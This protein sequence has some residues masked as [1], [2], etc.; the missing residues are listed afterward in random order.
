MDSNELLRKVRKIEIR[1][2]A[3]S[4]QIFAGEYHSAFKGRGMAFSEVREY[5]YGDDVRSM[6]WNVTAR[7]RAPYVK[8]YEEEREL[9]VMLLVD[10]SGSRL[11]GTQART[12]RELMAEIAAVLS[13]SAS[14][15]NDKVGALFFSSKVEK[16]IPPKKG[17]SHLL[18]IIR[19][20]LEFEPQEQG[21]DIGEALRFLTN[22]LKRRCTAFLLSDLMDVDAGGNPRY[23]EALKIAAGRHDLS[24][25]SVYDPRERKLPDVGLVHLRDAE[26][27][28]QLWVDTASAAVRR[29]Y[30]H[31]GATVDEQADRLLRRFKVD[32]VRIATD[33]DYVKDLIAF[34]KSRA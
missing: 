2:K 19:E 18:R 26:T 33:S 3:L 34:F 20:L 30:E 13:F 5:Q 11:F 24:A 7:L 27:G 29:S 9:T 4:H 1:T 10:V 31:W 12:K 16:F 8:V 6:D 28:R 32:S 15:N 17:R 23:E 14:I 21:T 22:A 25:I